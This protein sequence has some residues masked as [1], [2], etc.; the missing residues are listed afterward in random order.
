[1]VPRTS[2]IIP[3]YNRIRL[4]PRAVESILAQT[5]QDFEILIIDDASSD[6]TEAMVKERFPDPRIRYVRLEENTGAD[7]ARNHGLDLARGDV[8]AFLDSDDE[9]LPNALSRILPVSKEYGLVLAPYRLPDG[10]LSGF[11][12]EEGEVPFDRFICERKARRLKPVFSCARREAI[13]TLRWETKY[14]QALWYHRL[15]SKTRVY[16]L[17]EPL[18]IYHFD[19]GD[20]QSVTNTRRKPNAKLS[21]ERGRVLAKF[22]DDFGETISRNCRPRFGYYAYGAAVGLLL[23]GDTERAR[24]LARQAATSQ[25]RARYRMLYALTLLPSASSLLSLGFWFAKMK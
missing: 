16:Y 8:V 14:L 12:W 24:A 4:L 25:P 3:T 19:A 21:I 23:A 7:N 2:F 22:L 10:E 11:D 17:T 6:G 5:E 20:A 9:I 13:G 15:A 1:M 18:G